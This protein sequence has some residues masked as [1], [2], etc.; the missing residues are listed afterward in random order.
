MSDISTFVTPAWLDGQDADTIHQRMMENLPDDIDDTE[1]G[2]PWDFTKPTAIEKAELLEFEM[3]EAVK[4]MHYMFAYGIYLDYHAAAYHLKRRAGIPASG[5]VTINGSP[6]TIIPSGFQ[7]AVPAAGDTEAVIFETISDYIIGSEGSLE[8]SVKAQESGTIGNVAANTITIMV[9]PIVGIVSI[10][11]SSAFINGTDEEDDDTLRERIRE[12]LENADV[13]FVGCNADYKRWAKEVS[14]VGNVI[15]IPEWNGAGTVKVV[16]LDLNGEPANSTVVSAVYDHIVSPANRDMR[17]APIGATVT[18]A[19]PTVKTI[20][21]SCLLTLADGSDYNTVI[22]QIKDSFHSYFKS[23][24]VIKR[25]Y[26]GSLIMG[27]DGVNDYSNLTINGSTANITIHQ[28][29]YPE[30]GTFTTDAA[31][32]A[33]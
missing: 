32:E 4:L 30:L 15:V 27:V 10:T 3:M 25:N 22:N 9:Q 13:S 7:F 16:I 17:L 33:V 20:N 11:N 24:V 21:V 1:G 18:V 23:A 28:D 31:A 8:L 29:E 2:F 5:T 12:Y 6:G 19:A 26:I 14:G